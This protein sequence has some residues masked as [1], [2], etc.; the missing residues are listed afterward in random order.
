MVPVTG[1]RGLRLFAWFYAWL[2]GGLAVTLVAL[3]AHMAAFDQDRPFGTALRAWFDTNAFV[4]VLPGLFT[5][6]LF[7]GPVWLVLRLWIARQGDRAIGPR[8]AIFLIWM[9]IW[10]IFMLL[11]LQLADA[12]DVRTPPGPFALIPAP[13]D[14]LF[15]GFCWSR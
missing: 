3:P 9:V 7:L 1:L 12:D 14:L 13:F 2:A 4:A 6:V 15:E 8:P 11:E 10:V 5:S